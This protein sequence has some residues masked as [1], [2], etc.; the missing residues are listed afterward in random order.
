MPALYVEYDPGGVQPFRN[1]PHDLLALISFGTAEPF[2]SLHP[3]TELVR[4]LHNLHL[5]DMR[6]LLTF[7]D[8]DVEDDVD[9][10]TLEAARQPANRLEQ[11]VRDVPA[12]IAADEQ[13]PSLL[14]EDPAVPELLAELEPLATAAASARMRISFS[15]R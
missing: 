10:A 8:R 6:P 2:G 4:R 9:G 1:D 11:C 12:A 15:L 7:Y 3:L 13:A 14:A 5:V